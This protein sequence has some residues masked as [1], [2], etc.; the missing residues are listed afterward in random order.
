M[1]FRVLIHLRNIGYPAHWLSDFLS[2]TLSNKVVTSARTPNTSPLDIDES[3]KAHSKLRCSIAPFVPELTTLTLFFQPILPFAVLAQS[4]PLPRTIYQYSITLP[5]VADEI[6]NHQLKS[7]ERPVWNMVFFVLTHWQD[8]FGIQKPYLSDKL[9]KILDSSIDAQQQRK[10]IQRFRE[11]D[12]HCCEH[13]SVLSENRKGYLLN[14][15]G[16]DG[17]GTTG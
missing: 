16:E 11:E 10:K 4:L 8:L 1:M 2:Q 14:G 17:Y 12:F 13:F 9:R 15:G 6:H 5:K 3:M 7:H